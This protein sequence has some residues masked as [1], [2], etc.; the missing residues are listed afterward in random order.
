MADQRAARAHVEQLAQL[1]QERQA[2]AVAVASQPAPA[3]EAV[4]AQQ[5]GPCKAQ[6]RPGTGA[7]RAGWPWQ[8]RVQALRNCS[9]LSRTVPEGTWAV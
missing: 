1:D 4:L 3:D 2:L 8:W 5:P 6:C 9:L 7:A